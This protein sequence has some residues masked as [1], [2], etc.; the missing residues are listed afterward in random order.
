MLSR[1]ENFLATLHKR[2]HDYMPAAF[3]IDNMN[4]PGPFPKDVF[5]VERWT[6]IE[7]STKFQRRLGLDVLF[8]VSPTGV[9]ETVSDR[10]WRDDS[11]GGKI[12]ETPVGNLHSAAPAPRVALGQEVLLKQ[13]EDYDT[14]AWILEQHQYE[15]DET[16]IA[17]CQRHLDVIGQNGVVQVGGCPITPIMDAIRFW[18]GIEG[19]VFALCDFPQKVENMLTIA[20][21]KACQIYEMICSS[22]PAQVLVPWDDAT[23][24]LLSRD[25][26]EK[27]SAPCLKRFADIC[28]RHDKILANH[29]CGKIRGFADLYAVA[30]QDAIDWLAVPPTG[31]MSLELAQQMWQ[32]K[33]TPMV[34]PDPERVRYGARE[35]V[36]AHLQEMLDGA[37]LSGV[38]VLLPCPEGTPLENARVLVHILADRYGVRYEGD[39]LN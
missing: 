11:T 20:E 29:T 14:W 37:D 25:L 28:Y 4:Y 36:G 16:A 1:R 3:V 38:I 24:S 5:D 15:L 7:H 32:G 26:L 23:T 19:F 39:L 13:P 33:V 10:F 35:E 34:T 2:A 6:D 8:R 31:D 22:T 12:W 18:A 17:E 30:E 27:Y 21:E 9:R